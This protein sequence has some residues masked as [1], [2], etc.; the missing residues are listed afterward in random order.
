ML[1]W[2]R[3]KPSEPPQDIPGMEWVNA[4]TFEADF[5]CALNPSPPTQVL[6]G[7]GQHSSL[8]RARCGNVVHEFLAAEPACVSLLSTEHHQG[9]LAGLLCAVRL[10]HCS[11]R[12][13]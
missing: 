1:A 8:G 7:A 3:P 5:R 11:S 2:W 10:S 4:L 9:R 13:Q 6:A 12:A